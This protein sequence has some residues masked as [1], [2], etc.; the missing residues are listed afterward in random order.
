MIRPLV[1]TAPFAFSNSIFF[2]SAFVSTLI[3]EILRKIVKSYYILINDDQ[4]AWICIE[5]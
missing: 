3:L 5:R 1:G 2:S 4:I